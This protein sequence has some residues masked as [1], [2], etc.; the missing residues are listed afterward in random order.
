MERKKTRT[1][2]IVLL[3]IS[4]G[5]FV[6]SCDDMFKYEPVTVAPPSIPGA[7]YVGAETC[8]TC[9]DTETKYFNLSEHASVAVNITAEDAN[10]GQAEACETCHGPGSLHVEGMGDKS[11]IIKGK[12]E[13]C[14]AC[15]LNVKGEFM[16]QHHHPVPEGKM[17]C[18][19]CHD[20][21]GSDVRAT[22]GAMLLGK[23]ERCFKCH[24]EMRGPF[25]FEHEALR[26]G[27]TACHTP[28]GSINAKLL[29][30]GPSVTCVRCHIESKQGTV[31]HSG[32]ND[33][34]DCHAK[35]HGSN[36]AASS[37]R[38]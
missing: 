17:F 2:V 35:I 27:C 1:A 15:H 30:A 21:H 24:K 12:P 9:H 6:A 37:L 14:F 4:M 36:N 13:M 19:E 38:Y 22:G 28:H 33:C 23:D 3:C 29:I 5:I 16:L 34:I 8:A 7:K 18:T 25:V 10:A 11:K 26:E 31:H 32:R 20:M